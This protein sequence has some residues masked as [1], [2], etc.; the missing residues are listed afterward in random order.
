M[1]DFESRRWALSSGYRYAGSGGR[2]LEPEV[3]RNYGPGDMV[4]PAG[5][6]GLATSESEPLGF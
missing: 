3:S 1:E 4:E 5:G 2:P 6:D